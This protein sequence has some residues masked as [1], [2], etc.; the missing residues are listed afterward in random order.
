MRQR[1]LIP[2]AWIEKSAEDGVKLAVGQ[3]VVD[4]LAVY[5]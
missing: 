5:E 2:E 1:K 4:E 3:S